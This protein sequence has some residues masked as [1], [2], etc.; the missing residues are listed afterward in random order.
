MYGVG[1]PSNDFYLKKSLK[2]PNL[3]FNTQYKYSI[4]V[5][6]TVSIVSILSILVPQVLSWITT[7]VYTCNTVLSIP[8]QY[9]VQVVIWYPPLQFPLLSHQ[10]QHP[11]QIS[12]SLPILFPSTT[13]A[14]YS[15]PGWIGMPSG[16]NSVPLAVKLNLHTFPHHFPSESVHCLCN[17]SS[18][19]FLFYICVGV[20]MVS[21]TAQLQLCQCFLN[22]NTDGGVIQGTFPLLYWGKAINTS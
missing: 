13:L 9:L 7:T 10:L 15:S 1:V 22:R 17:I 19:A 11:V 16:G 21:T 5:P 18:L 8:I 4:G 6:V 20:T 14:C 3:S 12:G 2:E